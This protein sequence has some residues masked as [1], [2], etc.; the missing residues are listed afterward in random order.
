MRKLIILLGL[1]STSCAVLHKVQVGEVYSPP[2]YV[3]KPFEIKVSEVGFDLAQTSKV[4]SD[5]ALRNNSNND[6][7]ALLAF[8]ALFQMGPSTGMPVYSKDYAKNM[9]QVIYEKCPSGRVT[10]LM[11]IRENREYT[12]ISGEVSKIKGFCLIPKGA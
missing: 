8:I 9:M 1:M 5:V 3:L 4:A 6:A 10:G 12:V 11:S 2:G 7:G